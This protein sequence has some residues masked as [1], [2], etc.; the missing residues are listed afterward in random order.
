MAIRR[1]REHAW[2]HWNANEAL[3][4]FDLSGALLVISKEALARVGPFDEQYKLYFEEN[5][6]LER[7][8]IQGMKSFY[9]PSAGVLHYYNRSAKNESQAHAWFCESQRRFE[10]RYLGFPVTLLGGLDAILPDAP[11]AAC[12][13][14]VDDDAFRVIDRCDDDRQT[15]RIYVELSPS[16]FGYPAVRREVRWGQKWNLPHECFE[17]ME[18]TVYFARVFDANGNELKNVIVKEHAVV[19]QPEGAGRL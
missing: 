5:D 7:A 11:Y 19:I 1:W 2:K 17:S 13:G 18:E 10:K 16:R 14:Q 6:W 4:S 3:A 12:I 8:K 9:L 15:M